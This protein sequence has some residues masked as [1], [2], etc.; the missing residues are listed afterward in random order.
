MIETCNQGSCTLFNREYY[1]KVILPVA[2]L[3]RGLF[4]ELELVDLYPELPSIRIVSA[5]EQHS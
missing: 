4:V 5:H 3:A 2:E 1:Y